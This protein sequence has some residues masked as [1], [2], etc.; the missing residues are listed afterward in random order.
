MN[1]NLLMGCDV[2]EEMRVLGRRIFRS[3]GRRKAHSQHDRLVK[4]LLFRLS[5]ERYRIVGNQ[6]RVI[7]LWAGKEDSR[8]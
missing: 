3:M 6:V 8:L 5:Q 4:I 1:Y 2:E 7:V